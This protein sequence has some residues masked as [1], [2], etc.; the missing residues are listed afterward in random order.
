[1]VS[2]GF[3]ISGRQ[4]VREGRS[5][6]STRCLGLGDEL[7]LHCFPAAAPTLASVHR[8]AERP[9]LVGL[10]HAGGARR[11]QGFTQQ[12]RKPN[13]NWTRSARKRRLARR[14]LGSGIIH[15][16]RQPGLRGPQSCLQLPPRTR[17][18]R[19]DHWMPPRFRRAPATCLARRRPRSRSTFRSA[20]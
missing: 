19:T 4:Y 3:R 6:G 20:W 5:Q 8:G 15:W 13:S 16:S 10:G 18:P 2:C 11:A 7:F 12:S 1:M 9:P 17:H 14:R